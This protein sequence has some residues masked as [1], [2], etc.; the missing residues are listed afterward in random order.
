MDLTSVVPTYYVSAE[1]LFKVHLWL[2]N[3]G[4]VKK[5]WYKLN[6]IIFTILFQVEKRN[7][8]NVGRV[9]Q[10]VGGDGCDGAVDG[11][12]GQSRGGG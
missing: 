9:Q 10:V 11:R 4:L 8:Q 6:F 12:D 5:Y 7:T 1:A 2:L 3:T